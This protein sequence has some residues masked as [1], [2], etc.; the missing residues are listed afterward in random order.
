MVLG[1]DVDAHR[2]QRVRPMQRSPAEEERRYASGTE[3][4]IGEHRFLCLGVLGR[5]SYSEVW[6]AKVLGG[7]LAHAEV[8][9]KEVRCS[10]QGE[11]QQAIFEVQVALALER[12]AALRP[13]KELR[14]PRCLVYKVEPCE[15]GWRVRTAMTVVPGEALDVFIRQPLAR[16]QTRLAAL[17]RG[18]ALAAKLIRDL[19]PTLQ[20]LAPIAWHRDVNSHNV[21]VDGA[22]ESAFAE[23]H[24]GDAC[25]WLI[26]FGLAVDSQ[27]W[28]T[29]SG[30]WRTEYIG[31]DSRYWPPSSW[32]MHL[33]GPEGF[34]GRDDLCRQYQRRLDIHGLGITALELFCTL[35][36]SS[37]IGEEEQLG[38]WE[39]VLEAWQRYRQDV[40][41]WWSA[42]YQV[43]STG[44]D[45]APVQAQLLQDQIIE[46]LVAL[47]ADIRHA[48]RSCAGQLPEDPCTS[49]LLRTV[50]DMIDEG[51]ASDVADL[52]G[53]LG[54]APKPPPV[55]ASVPP[56]A[57]APMDVERQKSLPPRPSPL[58][59]TP[60]S[61]R[62]LV[63]EAFSPAPTSGTPLSEVHGSTTPTAWRTAP[64]ALHLM[65]GRPPP[66]VDAWASRNMSCSFPAPAAGDQ[67]S[68]VTM[69]SRPHSPE[70]LRQRPRS[71]VQ[72]RSPLRTQALLPQQA[73]LEQSEAAHLPTSPQHHPA[74]P[75]HE[76]ES[77]DQA[78]T[79]PPCLSPGD[80]HETH[81]S[82]NACT[83]F[84][85]ATPPGQGMSCWSGRDFSGLPC[86]NDGG[87]T[88]AACLP[89]SQS[90]PHPSPPWLPLCSVAS[91]TAQG[92]SNPLGVSPHP[93]SQD[94][95]AIPT[96]VCTTE[97]GAGAGDAALTTAAAAEEKNADGDVGAGPPFPS[98]LSELRASG[99]KPVSGAHLETRRSLDMSQEALRAR[100]RSLEASSE[101]H[102][103][104]RERIR[105]LE[106]SL[107][108]LGRESLERAK[109]GMEKLA[110]KYFPNAKQCEAMGMIAP[111]LSRL[112]EWQLTNNSPSQGLSTWHGMPAN[113]VPSKCMMPS[114]DKPLKGNAAFSV[115]RALVG[116]QGVGN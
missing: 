71:P 73:H 111:P 105:S 28:G 31:G 80:I 81:S 35:A 32:I 65:E 23:G 74:A 44:G 4:E 107:Q 50:A 36:L 46:Q 59:H 9:L 99:G 87:A 56:V 53:M 52:C 15:G 70:M 51:S 16:G 37:P 39:P 92:C 49:R 47:L 43:F 7:C 95:A 68:Q 91:M 78:V 38:A 40:W 10:S 97:A 54:E 86:A 69:F 58:Q 8:A 6:R 45:I 1:A 13:G 55:G 115:D 60:A 84:S 48:L 82:Q 88:D 114:L 109:V 25:F 100:I 96:C 83:A 61:P 64:P 98:Q 66:A 42:V 76:R 102:E 29:A 90:P 11:L 67:M 79:L 110:E 27:S 93:S 30:R 21:L 72:T 63:Q 33:L 106:E 57:S 14:V 113:T 17:Q 2:G 77:A 3:V 26:D 18:C 34:N 12:S 75:Q 5:G 85:G 19:A 116:T 41:Q 108:R 62:G 94:P 112:G 89:R 22:S 24:A 20:L 104:L 101:E 103:R